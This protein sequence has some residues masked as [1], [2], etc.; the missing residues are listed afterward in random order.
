MLYGSSE[1]TGG[2]LFKGGSTGDDF[3]QLTG[4]DSLSGTIESQRQLV[5][6]LSCSTY[7]NQSVAVKQGNST[8]RTNKYKFTLMVIRGPSSVQPKFAVALSAENSPKNPVFK[9][10]SW[11]SEI[12]KFC[13]KLIKIQVF[14][15]ND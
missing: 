10:F 4:D 9:E 15:V 11:F 12:F 7:N 5:N 3:N 2:V 14:Y 6:H 1:V 8:F 13:I